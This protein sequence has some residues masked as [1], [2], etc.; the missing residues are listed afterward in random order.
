MATLCKVKFNQIPEYKGLFVYKHHCALHSAKNT[1]LCGPARNRTARMY[2]NK[3]QYVKRKARM[4]NFKNPI[5]SVR[6]QT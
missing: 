3:L 4:C 2:E 6:R 5:Y 1:K